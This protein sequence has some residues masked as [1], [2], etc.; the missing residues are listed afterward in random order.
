[1]DIYPNAETFFIR[2]SS[3]SYFD[4]DLAILLLAPLYERI[5]IRPPPITINDA[6]FA[7]KVGM[8]LDEER[9]EDP[10]VGFDLP[11]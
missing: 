3:V 9:F 4:R 2:Q 11:L 8:W 10:F 6:E 5:G 7:S 1:M